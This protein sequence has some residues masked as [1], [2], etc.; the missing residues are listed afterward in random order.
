MASISMQLEYDKQQNNSF[1]P[2]TD[3]YQVLFLMLG[4]YNNQQNTKSLRSC[5]HTSGKL[6]VNK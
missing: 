5:S 1:V 6:T 2:S 4:V 3:I